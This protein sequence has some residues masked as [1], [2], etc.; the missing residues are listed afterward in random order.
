MEKIYSFDEILRAV[1]TG[2]I[3][4]SIEDQMRDEIALTNALINREQLK[5]AERRIKNE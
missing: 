1:Q 4:D 2:N 5:Q 3:T